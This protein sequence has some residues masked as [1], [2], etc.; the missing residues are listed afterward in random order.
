MIM[1]LLLDIHRV[2]CFFTFSWMI[3]RCAFL[4]NDLNN[5]SSLNCDNLI[6]Q[7]LVI[8]S[9]GLDEGVMKLEQQSELLRQSGKNNVNVITVCIS[10]AQ[11]T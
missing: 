6:H 7:V 1:R 2:K 9:D 5:E 11:I 10:S 8:F 3:V 4:I